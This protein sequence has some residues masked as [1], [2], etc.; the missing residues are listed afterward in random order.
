MEENSYAKLAE[1]IKQNGDL[2]GTASLFGGLHEE[3]DVLKLFVDY[4]YNETENVGGTSYT[5]NSLNFVAYLRDRFLSEGDTSELAESKVKPIEDELKYQKSKGFIID[6][7]PTK[8]TLRNFGMLLMD[9]GL[10]VDSNE[11]ARL[12]E[13]AL[14]KA[15]QIDPN[16]GGKVAEKE[17][18]TGAETAEAGAKTGT[19]NTKGKIGKDGKPISESGEGEAGSQ[20]GEVSSSLH[21][22]VE[23]GKAATEEDSEEGSEDD[24]SESDSEDEAGTTAESSEKE[25][26]LNPAKNNKLP[27]N[28]AEEAAGA[29]DKKSD[30]NPEK[31][32]KGSMEIPDESDKT[33]LAA[34]L[35]ILGMG[36]MQNAVTPQPIENRE[37]GQIQRGANAPQTKSAHKKSKGH[38]TKRVTRSIAPD[39]KELRR[40]TS[41][42]PTRLTDDLK[43]KPANTQSPEEEQRQRG[44]FRDQQKDSAGANSASPQN[45]KSPTG[46]VAKYA[47]IGSGLAMLVPTMSGGSAEA[48]SNS[49]LKIILSVLS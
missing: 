47:A 30:V 1:F 2:A 33:G 43:Q 10:G 39:G 12:Y 24:E 22:K 25:S 16:L 8:S 31:N 18:E 32:L 27:E 38:T 49:F 14:M 11:T 13:S 5:I 6:E 4:V 29:K 21:A 46:K 45:K 41:Q 28:Q 37:Q 17:S 35:P 7:P 15:Y 20:S 3:H 34:I 40:I 19:E 36:L 9:L 44:G 26:N 42:Q 48:A 23:D